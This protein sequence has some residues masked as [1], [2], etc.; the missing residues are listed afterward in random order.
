[1]RINKD[2]VLKALNSIMGSGARGI[3]T[4]MIKYGG[5]N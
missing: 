3:L 4:E 2:D 5:R 1:M